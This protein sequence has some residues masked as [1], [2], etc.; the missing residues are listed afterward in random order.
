MAV[1]G[2]SNKEGTNATKTSI[3]NLVDLLKEKGKMDLNSIALSLSADPKVIGQ[4][5]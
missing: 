1:A 5:S 3:D 4:K 2:D